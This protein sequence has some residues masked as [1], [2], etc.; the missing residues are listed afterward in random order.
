M[1]A[2]I[3]VLKQQGW[4]RRSGL[5]RG[6]DAEDASREVWP[7]GAQL[8]GGICAVARHFRSGGGD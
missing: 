7:I 6:S 8:R 2:C 5:E 4:R 3:V 1:G